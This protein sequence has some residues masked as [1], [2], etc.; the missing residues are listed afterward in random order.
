MNAGNAGRGRLLHDDFRGGEADVMGPPK[1][2]RRR[3]VWAATFGL[4]ALVAVVLMAARLGRGPVAS[5]KTPGEMPIKPA[6]A[7]LSNAVGAVVVPE[8]VTQTNLD[9]AVAATQKAQDSVDLASKAGELN[10]KGDVRE[11]IRLYEQALALTPEDENLHYNIGLVYARSGNLTNAEHH[12]RESLRLV[13]DY[14]EVHNNL[15]NLLLH[16]DRLDEA[17]KHLT[18]AVQLMPELVSAQNNLG[19]LRYKQHRTNDA[20]ACFQKAVQYDTNFWEGH[21]NLGRTLLIMGDRERG[22]AELRE[23]LRIN[24]SVQ[25]AQRALAKALGEMKEKGT[26]P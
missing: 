18:E 5:Q 14:P 23:T 1:A 6:A 24:P 20:L 12:Y 7:G 26:G 16:A 11:A 8:P 21:F 25:P 2:V 15:G 19:I 17:E 3:V 22:V 10:E 4:M 9:P 13:P